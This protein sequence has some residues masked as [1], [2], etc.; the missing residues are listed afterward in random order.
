MTNR[1]PLPYRELNMDLIDR[2]I[3]G[4]QYGKGEEVA[5]AFVQITLY[6]HLRRSDIDRHCHVERSET[7]HCMTMRFFTLFRMTWISSILLNA[8]C[9]PTRYNKFIRNQWMM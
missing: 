5:D 2:S 6:Q 7:S 9:D 4:D 1:L 8:C 3:A